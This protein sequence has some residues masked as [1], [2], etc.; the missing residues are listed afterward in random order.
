MS[1]QIT[2]RTTLENLKREAKRW[3][4]AL[5]ANA[6][7]A[8]ARLERALPNAPASPTLARS[9]STRSPWSTGCRD[10]TRSKIGSPGTRRCGATT[11]WPTR[12]STRT[13][14]AR[15]APCGSSGTTSGTGAPGTACGGTSAWI[16]ARPN[17]RERRGRRHHARRGAAPRGSRAGLRELGGARCL[18]GIRPARTRRIAAKSVAVYSAGDSESAQVGATLAGLGRGL[19]RDA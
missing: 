2:P 16:S 4:K 17:S 18:R 15:K 9:C 12:W 6:G 11:R 5:R 8:R 3:L 1:R 7:E 14:R 19:C 10:G 13:A